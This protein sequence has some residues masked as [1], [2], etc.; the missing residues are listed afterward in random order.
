[1]KAVGVGIANGVLVTLI[2]SVIVWFAA[3]V[4]RVQLG[5]RVGEVRA[6]GL[7][8]SIYSGL[9]F[10]E[11]T[12]RLLE[13]RSHGRDVASL[14]WGAWVERH[15]GQLLDRSP[16][17]VVDVA[18]TWYGVAHMVWI[19]A[20]GI[21]LLLKAPRWRYR[22]Y[23]WAL[24]VSGLVALAVFSVFPTASPAVTYGFAGG[25]SSIERNAALPYAAMP[26][27]HMCWAVVGAWSLWHFSRWR[28]FLIGYVTVTF[29]VV[30]F[31][32]NHFLLDC[33][34]GCS[35]AGIV[36]LIVSRCITEGA[37]EPALPAASR[38]QP[39]TKSSAPLHA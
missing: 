3:K 23:K 31:T 7:W 11:G 5:K 12:G 22:R 36:C 30:I 1:V 35:L 20:V 33:L 29:A 16:V 38:P 21:G 27:L 37:A 32:G 8:F 34:A 18:R 17:L 10:S 9:A 15:A 14:E 4:L 25:L 6:F 19:V 13:A 28:L 26:S 2:L 39:P 24:L